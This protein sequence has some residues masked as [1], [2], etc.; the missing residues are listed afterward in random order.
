[1]KISFKK[2]EEPIENLTKWENLGGPKSKKH[3]KDGRSSYE[4]AAF[5]IERKDQL[6]NLVK[7]LL[8]EFE[9]YEQDFVCEPEAKTGLGKGMGK[10]GSRNHD[11]LMVGKDVVIGVEAK[12][13]EKFDNDTISEKIKKQTKDDAMNTRAQKL[14]DFLASG[15]EN[16]QIGYQL[17]S[18]TRGTMSAAAK[19]GYKKCIQ[20][21]LIFEGNVKK[22]NDYLNKCKKNDEDFKEFL[23]ITKA[24]NGDIKRTIEGQEV[25]CLIKK[26]KVQVP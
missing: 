10:G 22:E 3:W 18:A 6:V 7:N 5:S 24:A 16:C 11:L 17:F 19:I 14:I 1:M 26:V 13:S 12:V 20:L 4:M 23:K 8:Q 15:E 2:R 21:V 25:T 9:L